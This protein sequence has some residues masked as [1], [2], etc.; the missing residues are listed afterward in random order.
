MN[1]L[2]LPRDLR[3]PCSTKFKSPVSISAVFAEGLL[4]HSDFN[5]HIVRENDTVLRDLGI[6]RNSR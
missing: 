5:F 3:E 4:R 2:A 6:L 1:V